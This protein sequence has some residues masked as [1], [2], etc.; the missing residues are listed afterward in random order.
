MMIRRKAT[1]GVVM[2][3]ALALGGGGAALASSPSHKPAKTHAAKASCKNAQRHLNHLAGLQLLI[4]HQL[5]LAETAS[6]SAKS[7]NNSLRELRIQKRITG[8]AAHE[9]RLNARV[10]LLEQACHLTPQTPSH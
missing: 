3:A 6:S 8:L 7:T 9:S 5:S 2:S 1:A 4:Q 10:Q